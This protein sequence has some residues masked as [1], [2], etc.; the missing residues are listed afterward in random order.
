MIDQRKIIDL[1]RDEAGNMLA[2]GAM[3]LIVMAALVGGG[4]DM[5]RAYKAQSRL[6]AACDAG[7]L[8]G[9]KAVSTQGFDDFAESEAAAYFDNNFDED[10]QGARGTV[11]T[12][13]SSDNGGTVEATAT[14]AVKSAI[15]S[16]FGFDTIN[17]SVE[18]S[19]SMGVGNSDVTMVLDSTGSMGGSIEWHGPSKL[20]MLQDAMKNFYDTVATATGGGNEADDQAYGKKRGAGD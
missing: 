13:T 20:S 2:I 10:E 12:P 19:A 14:T 8:A 18:C 9:R 6:Q 5:S 15:M 11:F 3:G 1:A 17:V 4:V 16:I 7:V